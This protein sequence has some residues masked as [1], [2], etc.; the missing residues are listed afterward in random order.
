MKKIDWKPEYSGLEFRV[1]VLVEFFGARPGQVAV[2]V[3][4]EVEILSDE[5][6]SELFFSLLRRVR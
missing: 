5:E 6:R 4:S 1:I 3:I 2:D